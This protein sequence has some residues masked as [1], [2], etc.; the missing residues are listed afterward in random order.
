MADVCVGN[1]RDIVLGTRAL[2]TACNFLNPKI[3]L[4]SSVSK[5]HL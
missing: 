4:Q 3:S 1:F 5:E 2:Q